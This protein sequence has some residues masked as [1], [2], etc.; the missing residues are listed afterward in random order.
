[1]TSPQASNADVTASDVGLA[2]TVRVAWSLGLR[3]FFRYVAGFAWAINVGLLLAA[4]GWIYLYGESRGI[5]ELM[6]YQIGAA[7]PTAGIIVRDPSRLDGGVTIGIVA[8]VVA[9]CA[10]VVMLASLFAGSA[11]FRTTRAWLVFMAVLCGWLGLAVSWPTIYW[12]GQQQRLKSVL[13]AADAMVEALRSSWP[14]V[15]TTLPDIGPFLA[16]PINK[17]TALMPLSEAMF[18]KTD[19]RFSAVER[20]GDEVMRFELSGAELGAWLEWRGDGSEPRSFV[21]GL[22][23]QYMVVQA[24]RLS[25]KWFLVRY[26]VAGLAERGVPLSPQV[27]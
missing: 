17:P 15:D 7:D 26:R 12:F 18:P 13:P 8:G 4:F 23:T 6:K 24:A 22:D 10:A 25:D 19:L 3:S 27:R 21:G 9:G 20:T 1:M 16:Y 5:V 14:V 11:R 2:T